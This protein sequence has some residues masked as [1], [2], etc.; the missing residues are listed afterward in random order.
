MAKF[1]YSF[2]LEIIAWGQYAGL[3]WGEQVLTLIHC[4]AHV[5][6]DNTE[7]WFIRAIMVH[8][9]VASRDNA[10]YA[11]I[12]ASYWIHYYYNYHYQT[13]TLHIFT[14]QHTVIKDISHC[15][16][17][18]THNFSHLIIYSVHAAPTVTR[19]LHLQL[20]YLIECF[21]IVVVIVSG[22]KNLSIHKSIQINKLSKHCFVLHIRIEDNR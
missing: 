12:S 3:K 1:S 2:K 8:V 14:L 10:G 16:Y 9:H 22:Y 5:N 20:L 7:K 15:K 19:I 21:C 11:L 13:I 18:N 4:S 17:I 6:A